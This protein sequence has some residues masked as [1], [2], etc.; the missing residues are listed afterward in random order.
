MSNVFLF[1]IMPPRRKR[2]PATCKFTHFLFDSVLTN[3]LASKVPDPAPTLPIPTSKKAK[4]NSKTAKAGPVPAPSAPVDSPSAPA[5]TTEGDEDDD[6]DVLRNMGLSQSRA[7]L[8]GKYLYD[9][10]EDEDDEDDDE[11][12]V[13]EG[14]SAIPCPQAT[15][16]LL[17]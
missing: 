15:C 12:D 16:S 7:G 8:H 13:F 1:S 5:L 3:L 6:S 9:V 2:A 17:S 10:N 4:A 11:D 14:M